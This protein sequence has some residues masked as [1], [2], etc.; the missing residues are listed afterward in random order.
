[1]AALLLGH[2]G[3]GLRTS[4]TRRAV[5]PNGLEAEWAVRPDEP[6][7]ERAVRLD[8]PVAAPAVEVADCQVCHRRPGKRPHRRPAPQKTM[9]GVHPVP[10]AGA[11]PP[12]AAGL[13]VAS[14]PASDLAVAHENCLVS[15]TPP[16]HHPG[17]ASRSQRPPP[18]RTRTSGRWPG[19]PR[20]RSRGDSIRS[21]PRNRG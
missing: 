12:T 19:F 18:P 1:P 21:K 17:L 5:W 3:R 8:R 2:R 11:E 9:A 10:P 16:V 7:V 4:V 6:V 13:A 14:G 20:H 15:G